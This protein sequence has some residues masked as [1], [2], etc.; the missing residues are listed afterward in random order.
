MSAGTAIASLVG[1]VGAGGGVIPVV[2]TASFVTGSLAI[3]AV[4]PTLAELST[5]TGCMVS[6]ASGLTIVGMSIS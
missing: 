2:S 1:A 5:D 6:N 4:S 3:S